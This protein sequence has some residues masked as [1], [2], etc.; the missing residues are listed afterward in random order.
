M[1]SMPRWYRLSITGIHF[2]FT[3]FWRVPAW[4]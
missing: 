2:S 4:S 1:P 3:T